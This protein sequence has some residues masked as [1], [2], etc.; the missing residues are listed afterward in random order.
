VSLLLLFKST[1]PQP[2]PGDATAAFSGDL[3]RLVLPDNVN[4][5]DLDDDVAIALALLLA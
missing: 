4:L 3:F 5:D 1:T 2:P